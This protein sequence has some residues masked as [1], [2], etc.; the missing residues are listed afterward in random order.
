MRNT[1]VLI[2]I[3]LAQFNNIAYANSEFKTREEA[4][5]FLNSYCIDL[6]NF[7]KGVVKRQEELA[8]QEKWREFFE[9]GGMIQ[10]ASQIYS[11]FC[12]K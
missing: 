5:E 3:S 1:L 2:C 8:K 4:D 10:G 6:I 9:H 11:N 7:T 12:K